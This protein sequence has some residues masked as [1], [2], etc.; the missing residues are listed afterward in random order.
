LRPLVIATAVYVGTTFTTVGTADAQRRSGVVRLSPVL[1]LSLPFGGPYINESWLH[2]QQVTSAILGG[3]IDVALVPFLGLEL[4]VGA[5]RGLVAVRDS[6]NRVRDIPATLYLSSAKAVLWI[7]PHI[8]DGV[9]M[10]VSSG[11]G[12]IGRTGKAW[13]D[14]R[15]SGAATAWVV[16]LGGDA[17][18]SRRGPM[19]FRFELEDYISTAQFNVGLPTETRPLLHH[20]IVWSLGVSFPIMG[21]WR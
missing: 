16:A 14:T 11:V 18:L 12:L 3:K 17:R 19:E 7:N 4:G 20:D 2:K 8:K 9:I 6:T 5:G 13:R 15:P 1:A 10:H 21:R